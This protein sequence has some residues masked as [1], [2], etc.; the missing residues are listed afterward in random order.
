MKKSMTSQNRTFLRHLVAA[1]AG[2]S[3]LGANV[4]AHAQSALDTA[5]LD[6]AG[7]WTFDSCSTS[8]DN[9]DS[10]GNNAVA[11]R[12]NLVQCTADADK[13]ANGAANFVVSKN[14]DGSPQTNVTIKNASALALSSKL[15][16]S[17]KIKPN[18]TPEGALV[19]KGWTASG[20]AQKAF[21]LGIQKDAGG[22]AFLALTV[23][24]VP[25]SGTTP[26]PVTVLS[27]TKVPASKWSR[28]GATYDT[29]SGIKL[30]I[31]GNQVGAGAESRLIADVPAGVTSS[32]WMG[33]GL[34]G[35][36]KG[37]VGALDDL[38]ISRGSC[39]DL[40]SARSAT[41]N[42][43]LMITNL[44]VV[45]DP[46]RTVGEGP[47]TFARLMQQMVPD[48]P[49]NPQAVKDAA[50]DMVEAMFNTWM[51]P[52]TVNGFNVPARTGINT[53]VLS[54][55]P[56]IN[57]KLNLAAAPLRLL[58]IVNRTDQRDLAKGLAGEGRFV[59]GVLDSGGNQTQ[60]T[61]ILE[62][63]LPAQTAADIRLWARDWHNL[64][65]LTV[66]SEAYNAA[67]QA[68][69]DRFTSRGAAPGRFND[70]AI[71][72]V[73][74]NEL[75]LGASPWELRQFQL[76]AG[77]G[78]TTRL[79]PAPVGNNPDLK[80]NAGHLAADVAKLTAYIN[81]SAA[82]IVAE[83]HEVPLTTGSPAVPFLA[84]SSLNNFPVWNA[85]NLVAPSGS[86]VATLRHKFAVNTCNGCHSGETQTSF[87]H[88]FPRDSSQEAFLSRFL[89]GDPSKSDGK[90]AV[91]DPVASGVVNKFNDLA[92]RQS[93]MP[94]ML[95]CP[96]P[97]AAA[98]LAVSRTTT[99]SSTTSSST[100]PTLI[101]GI[102]RVH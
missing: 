77:A 63:R 41:I 102:S 79:N 2:I 87:L 76:G 37:Y 38:W 30:Y 99:T 21:Q 91:S 75:A 67:L 6:Y 88:V 80:F 24:V 71:N 65:T 33:G 94:V 70:N 47:W 16:L 66:P 72:Q 19:T 18:A 101:K 68:I 46:V 8:F 44:S 45:E 40:D 93:D 100:A 83:R 53:V 27:T 81:G 25:T 31:D 61:L 89:T 92:R 29:A 98:R 36:T 4:G 73:R 84:G 69:T 59:F 22:N 64:G 23:W 13:R 9:A 1:A 86:T 58:A 55:W 97:A 32:V 20:T 34:P 57:G 54:N 74:T 48:N 52:Q 85:P 62:Y 43:E 39:V 56:R 50:S 17:L 7:R 78:G 28:V 14:G 3:C 10:S 35:Q 5:V 82:D 60:F 11:T 96:A 95:T 42:K 49:S 26:V 12:G 51:V 15:A 90:L